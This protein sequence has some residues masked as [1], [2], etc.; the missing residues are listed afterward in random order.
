MLPVCV[1]VCDHLLRMDS[2]LLSSHTCEE[3]WLLFP[4]QISIANSS[5]A[6]VQLAK[7]LSR[8]CWNSD[9]LD[10]VHILYMQLQQLMFMSLDKA[11]T[12]AFSSHLH[13]Y[14]VVS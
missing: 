1:Q 13:T 9:W 6:R 3:N 10:L 12:Q 2:L 4:Q 5:S 14:L 11:F 8:P 7:P